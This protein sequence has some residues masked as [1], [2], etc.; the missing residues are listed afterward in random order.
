MSS[1]KRKIIVGYG[2]VDKV[3]IGLENSLVFIG[4]PCAI[5]SKEHFFLLWQMKLVKY[6]IN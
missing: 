1:R 4:G 2:D 5:E 6:V 3:S